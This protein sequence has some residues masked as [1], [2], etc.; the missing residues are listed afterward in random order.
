MPEATVSLSIEVPKAFLQ[1][2]LA[3]KP[4]WLD[5]TN[6]Q[7]LGKMFAGGNFD[8]FFKSYEGSNKELSEAQR[9]FLQTVKDIANKLGVPIRDPPS[10]R[11]A[12]KKAGPKAATRAAEAPASPARPTP[13]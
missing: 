9:V 6:E 4:Q 13:A 3:R 1:Q 10:D 11:P 5:V 8:E 2:A 7:F 12:R